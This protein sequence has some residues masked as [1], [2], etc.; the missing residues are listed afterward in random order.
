[1]LINICAFIYLQIRMLYIFTITDLVSSK[2]EDKRKGSIIDPVL[3]LLVIM[4][5]RLAAEHWGSSW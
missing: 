3:R 2:V 5:P 4:S 1:M